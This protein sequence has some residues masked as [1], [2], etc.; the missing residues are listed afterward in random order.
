M[1]LQLAVVVLVLV[2]V[3]VEVLVLVVST[4][5]SHRTLH[6]CLNAAPKRAWLHLSLVCAAQSS[7]SKFPLHRSNVDV[8]VLEL[9][10][11]D[12]DVEVAV[13]V[14]L[15]VLVLVL[16]LLV[17][18]VEVEVLLFT[19]DVHNTGQVVLIRSLTENTVDSQKSTYFCKVCNDT[20]VAS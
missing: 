13:L 1:L 12:V 8:D 16:V 15:V 18:L 5:E 7:G 20:C 4:H 9:V 19:Q 14:E 6:E 11:V 2:V 17:V 3:D 10:D